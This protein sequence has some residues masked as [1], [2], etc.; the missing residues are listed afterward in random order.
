[1]IASLGQMKSIKWYK[2]YYLK[3]FFLYN[4]SLTMRVRCTHNRTSHLPWTKEFLKVHGFKSRLV[5]GQPGQLVTIPTGHKT[6]NSILLCFY[7]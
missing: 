3:S 2:A 4:Y 6:I 1:M 5:L 7:S